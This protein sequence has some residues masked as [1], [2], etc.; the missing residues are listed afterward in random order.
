MTNDTNTLT[1]ALKEAGETLAANLTT[2]GVPSTW[3]E[4]LTTLIGKVL[5]ITP[6]PGPTPTPSSISLTADKS[7]LSYADSE[8]ATLSATV[9]DSN[10]D[11][12]SGVTVTF[13]NGST[14]MGT[15]DTNSSGVA[16]KTYASTGAGDLSFTAS[17]GTISS[18]TY[19]IEDCTYYHESAFT[20]VQ[21]NFNVSL[22]SAFEVSFKVR[23]TSS[24]GNSSYLEVGGNTGNTALFGQ[25]G[26]GGN[27]VLR[28]YNSE[29]S[30]SYNDTSVGTNSSGVDTSY[31]WIKNGSSNTASMGTTTKTVSNSL[32]HGKIRKLSI[33]NNRI[34]ELKVKPL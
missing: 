31:K 17:V 9:L 10:D 30:S 3:D 22:P 23:R 20:S 15:A 11:P 25:I 26:G 24:S 19:S 33:T 27:S 8:S 29:G 13:Y 34:F 1:G 32:T 6:G 16:T 21:D 18:E 2:Q 28:L 14:S 12:M 4:G 7:I 5:D